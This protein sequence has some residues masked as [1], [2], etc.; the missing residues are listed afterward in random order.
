MTQVAASA[1]ALAL[2][3]L[4]TPLVSGDVTIAEVQIRTPKSGELR[5]LSLSS[6]LNLEYASLELLLPRITTP[7]LSKQD[8]AALAPSDLIQLGSEV[9]DFLLPKDAKAALSPN[10]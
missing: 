7:I 9:M 6:L 10:A 3:A 4:D 5:G 1:V 2:V 8:V